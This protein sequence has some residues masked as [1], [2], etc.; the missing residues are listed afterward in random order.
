MQWEA[1]SSQHLLQPSLKDS[2]G[3]GGQNKLEKEGGSNG[4]SQKH[5][6]RQMSPSPQN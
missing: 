4:K 6:D 5:P 2:G 3:E 1:Q